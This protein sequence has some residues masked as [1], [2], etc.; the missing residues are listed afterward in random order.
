MSERNTEFQFVDV[1]VSDIIAKLTSVYQQ[2]VN[3]TV[4]PSSPEKL[5]LS[6]VASAIVQIYQNINYA[7]NQNLPSRA[8]GENLD[9]LA[10]LF[11]MTKRPDPVAATVPVEFTISEAQTTTLAI[12][13]GT[14]VTNEDGDPVFET[15]EEAIIEIG[16]TSVTVQC[17]C[18][19]PGTIGNGFEAGQLN[20]CVDMFPYFESCANTETSAGGIDS[21][22]DDEFYELLV[23]SEGA[24]SCAGPRGA[25]KYFA[26]SV[27]LNVADVVVNSPDP[28][29]VNIYVLM[30]DGTIADSATKALITAACN[31]NEVRPLTDLVSVEDA[32]TV[33]YNI[34]LTYYMSTSS[35]K[36]ATE[37]T[38]DVNAAIDEYK[39]WQ[40]GKLGRD[41]N[42]SKLT[43]L[44]VAAGAKR[45][46]ITSPTYTALRDGN[47]VNNP[48]PQV[49][50]VGTVTVTNGGYED[51]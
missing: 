26:K 4:H 11:Y 43:Q 50:V 19:T 40:S 27:S 42:P 21:P 29:E 31:D 39:K 7:A 30:D 28:G 46:V 37:I 6:W 10:Q 9:A 44:V 35:Q 47:D 23:N 8:T 32:D 51:E 25:Y 14:Q 13:A 20:E 33:S 16:E 22:N 45:V 34:T 41:I 12:P 2:I 18:Q 24:W 36:S 1:N 3:R 5:F 15:V 49:A 38:A 17:V 48:V